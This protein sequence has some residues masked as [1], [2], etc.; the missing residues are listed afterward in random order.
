VLR[1]PIDARVWHLDVDSSQ[2]RS[3]EASNGKTV[4]LLKWYVSWV[5]TAVRQVGLYLRCVFG[6][7]REL[8]ASTQGPP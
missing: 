2:P 3:A 6:G 1:V 8:R 5:Q 7:L 4:R